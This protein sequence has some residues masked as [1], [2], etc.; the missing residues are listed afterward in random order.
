MGDE[1]LGVFGADLGAIGGKVHGSRVCLGRSLQVAFLPANPPYPNVGGG[2]GGAVADSLLVSAQGSGVIAARQL[3]A[4][5]YAGNLR[6]PTAYLCGRLHRFDSLGEVFA[7][8]PYQGEGGVAYAGRGTQIGGGLGVGS[9]R[10]QLAGGGV[11]HGEIGLTVRGTSRLYGAK[12]LIDSLV[13]P[14]FGQVGAA[15]AKERLPVVRL[16]GD[17]AAELGDRLIPASDIDILAP[18]EVV[19]GGVIVPADGW[20][21]EGKQGDS[22]VYRFSMVLR[23]GVQPSPGH[24]LEFAVQASDSASISG[25]TANLA[26][27]RPLCI[28]RVPGGAET[29]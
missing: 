1:H 8:H 12:P 25:D 4:S 13:G 26:S 23:H 27:N 11:G 17:G 19:G 29:I 16:E 9:S 20:K 21:R 6:I 3:N 24:T 15:E 7:R 22:Y 10:A 2:V 14:A 28:R 18:G 5:I